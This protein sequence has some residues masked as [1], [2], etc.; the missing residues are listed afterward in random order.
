[1]SLM[2]S[3]PPTSLASLLRLFWNDLPISLQSSFSPL[4]SFFFL[5]IRR[6]PRPTP[7]PYPPLFR[8]R[9]ALPPR[10]LP[11]APL[12]ASFWR[13]P[14]RRFQQIGARR[15]LMA[16][17]LTPWGRGESRQLGFGREREETPF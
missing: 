15:R 9:W 8:S 4:C 10:P 3:I 11:Q 5:M 14:R 17:E 13:P 12:T 7:F 16:R 1:M 6:P 2:P